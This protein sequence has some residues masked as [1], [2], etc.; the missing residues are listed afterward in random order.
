MMENNKVPIEL[1]SVET[2]NKGDVFLWRSNSDGH[3]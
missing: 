2:L 1:K 3:F